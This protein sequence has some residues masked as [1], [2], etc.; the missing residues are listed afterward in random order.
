MEL[1]SQEVNRL[2]RVK[3][4]EHD[5][6]QAATSS[7]H[8]ILSIARENGKL[9]KDDLFKEVVRLHREQNDRIEEHVAKLCEEQGLI[10]APSCLT[11]RS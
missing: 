3:L 9:A 1:N 11:K 6:Q 10:D 5:L 4:F 2:E 7:A 8:A